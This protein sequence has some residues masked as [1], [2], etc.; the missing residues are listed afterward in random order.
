MDQKSSWKWLK[1]GIEFY[2][3]KPYMST[4]CTDR[5]SDWSITPLSS[6][7]SSTT[8][9]SSTSSSSSSSSPSDKPAATSE[10]ERDGGPEGKTLWVY[11][12]VKDADGKEVERRPL[13]EIAWFFA[14]EE[15]WEIGVGGAVARPTVEG[16]EGELKGSFSELSV[17]VLDS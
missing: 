11:H 15:G 1:T 17:E 9:S 8:S 10:V 14:E 2:E 3:G 12:I 6:S 13:R 16:G 5:W 4:V 7:P